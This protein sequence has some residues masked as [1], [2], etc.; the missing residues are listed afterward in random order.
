MNSKMINNK[1]MDGYGLHVK[2]PFFYS[3]EERKQVEKTLITLIIDFR[4]DQDFLYAFLPAR[5]FILYV[6]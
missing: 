3:T 2:N 4:H 5:K 1:N 6:I